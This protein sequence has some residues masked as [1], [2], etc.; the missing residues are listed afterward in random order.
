LKAIPE[1][2]DLPVKALKPYV[3]AWH[4]RAKPNITTQAFDESWIDFRNGWVRIKYARGENPMTQVLEAACRS[5]VPEVAMQFEQDE[6]RLLVAVCRE[7]QRRAGDGPFF[8]SCR[9]AGELVGVPFKLA[10]RWLRHLVDEEI[11]DEVSPG[12]LAGNRAARYRYLG[13]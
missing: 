10:W 5:Q 3:R 6:L 8:L 1:L 7:A 2:A 9:M 13:D 12:S 4:E 11:L